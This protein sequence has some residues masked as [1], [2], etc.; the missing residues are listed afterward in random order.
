MAE[1]GLVISFILFFL[2]NSESFVGRGNCRV[3]VPQSRQQCFAGNVGYVKV[4]PD[5][6]P[7]SSVVVKT[8]K[9]SA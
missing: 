7:L 3:A 8:T 5:G 2:F 6:V 1:R 4:V 9:G